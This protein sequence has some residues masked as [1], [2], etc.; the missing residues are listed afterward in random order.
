MRRPSRLW[1]PA[2]ALGA[3]AL[4]ALI[5][6]LSQAERPPVGLVQHG[7][8][9]TGMNYVYNPRTMDKVM[10]ANAIPDAL[11]YAGDVGPK[12][13]AIY[14]NVHVLGDVNASEFARLMV[15]MTTWVAPDQ[16]CA[17]CHNLADFSD[18]S[19]Y[20]K[21]VARRMLQM[22]RHINAD[23]TAH[24]AQTGVTCYTCHRGQL[25]PP[26][27][28]FNNPGPH[29][30]GGVSQMPAGKNHPAAMAGGSA[31][32]ADPF[33][34]FLEQTDTVRVSSATPL[35]SG[36]RQSIKQTEWT[37]S[38]MMFFSQALGV[39]C[40]YCHNTRSFY[41]WDQSTPQR[42]TAW[43]GIRM[44]RDLNNDFLDRLAPVFP[45]NRLGAALG[46]APKI[47]CATCHNGVYKP[48]FGV[49]MLQSFP[50]LK[51]APGA[52]AAAQ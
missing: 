23:W 52:V 26:N 24:V 36:D 47:N 2:A 10:A 3:L 32:P 11:P 46:D 6:I 51:G 20:T 5:V 44:V 50:E 31:L 48:L 17:A 21:V 40:D 19:L 35:Q 30:A 43:Y 14:Q 8:R 1:L 45:P 29:Q 15:N 33:T 9:G 41:A 42:V 7:R 28:W 13:S 27:I 16:G 25:V 18:D 34:P 22:V 39:N 49:S 38:L 12:A 4:A 37:Y